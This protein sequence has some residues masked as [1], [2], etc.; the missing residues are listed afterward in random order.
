MVAASL[1]R[2]RLAVLLGWFL[3]SFGGSHVL[4][5]AAFCDAWSAQVDGAQTVSSSFGHPYLAPDRLLF[6]GEMREN[7]FA[8]V[9]GTVAG[10]PSAPFR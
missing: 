6:V 2:V 1:H 9:L 3:V 4:S 8:F 7:D 10:L 5:P